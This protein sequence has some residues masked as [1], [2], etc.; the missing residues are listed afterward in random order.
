[1]VS[2]L[3][4]QAK[5][6][7]FT[8]QDFDALGRIERA[9]LITSLA[10]IRSVHLIGTRGSHG[11][12]L[13]IISSFSHLGSSPALFGFV[14]RPNGEVRRDTYENLK[15]NPF[16]T[17]NSIQSDFIQRA[18]ATSAKWPV[19]VSEFDACHLTQCVLDGVDAPAVYESDAN[20]GLKKIRE[21]EIPENGTIL[22]LAKLLFVSIAPQR[23]L[24][25]MSVC[26]EGSLGGTS[27]T[28]YYDALKYNVLPY[29]TIDVAKELIQDEKQ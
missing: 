4:A 9:T 10:G 12:N 24:N 13:A 7:I 2:D 5:K 21:I 15:G 27:L 19:D 28:H 3:N 17:I 8:P 20:L 6:K 14:I 16:F 26:A 1:M 29:A 18:H 11:D 22:I 25:D 23:L